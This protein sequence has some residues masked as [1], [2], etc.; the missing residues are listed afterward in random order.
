MICYIKIYLKVLSS[1]KIW[2]VL[3]NLIFYKNILLH[4]IWSKEA[5]VGD[6]ELGKSKLYDYF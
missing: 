2:Y 6:L 4:L 5:S 1:D 3:F